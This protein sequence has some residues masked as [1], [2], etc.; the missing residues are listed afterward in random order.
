MFTE[1]TTVQHIVLSV[2]LHALGMGAGIFVW[3]L[4]PRNPTRSITKMPMEKVSLSVIQED[5]TSKDNLFTTQPT[6]VR[7]YG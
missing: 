5:E 4:F 3:H 7:N 1:L 2:V 6:G